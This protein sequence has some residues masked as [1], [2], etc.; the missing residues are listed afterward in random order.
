MSFISLSQVESFSLISARQSR[1]SHC[2]SHHA[3]VQRHPACRLSMWMPATVRA[4]YGFLKHAIGCPV[5]LT[6]QQVHQ[7]PVVSEAIHMSCACD[8][9]GCTWS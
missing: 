3:R 1:H 4:M 9:S 2:A 6:A 5:L 7:G 8:S